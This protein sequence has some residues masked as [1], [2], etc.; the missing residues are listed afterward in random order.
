VSIM[1]L[2]RRLVG[3]FVV[4]CGLAACQQGVPFNA[5]DVTGASYGPALRLHDHNGQ[6]RTLADFHGKAVV[7]FFGYTNCPDVCPTSLAMLNQVLQRLGE[8]DAARVQVL[9]VTVDPQRD[10]PQQLKAYMNAFNP[11]FLA[12]TGSEAEIA[13]VAREFKVIY[14]KHGDI[15]SGHYSVDHTAG[16]FVFDTQGRPRLFARHG[17]TAERLA[18]DLKALLAEH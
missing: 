1:V 13:T 15:A 10:T 4:L 8:K 16:C 11:A 3:V 6:M 17:E 18:A 12:L 14:E 9:F 7:I 5:T 2:L